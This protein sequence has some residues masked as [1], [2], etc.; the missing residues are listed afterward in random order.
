MPKNEER[1]PATGAGLIR[2]FKEEGNGIKI[3]PKSVLFLT[4]GTIIFVLFL[5]VTGR[6]IFGI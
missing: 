6:A 2:Y 3:S 4:A 5:H 1:M